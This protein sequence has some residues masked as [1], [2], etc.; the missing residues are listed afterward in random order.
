MK[1][2]IL[3]V[4]IAILVGCICF[5][6]LTA[7]N[8]T[9]NID[10]TS[11]SL[12]S[13]NVT[14]EVGETVNLAATIYPSNATDK[15]V[16]W[17]SSNT[18]IATVSNGLV[19]AKAEGI[20]IITVKTSNNK[21]ATCSI[22]VTPKTI[23]VTSVSL[24]L[25]N[26]TLE[27]GET[28][29]LTATI[30]PSNATDKS[31]T[32]RSSNTSVATVSNGLVTA[33]AEGITTITVK[34]SNNKTATCEVTVNEVFVFEEYGTGYALVA[35]KGSDS[36]VTVPSVYNGKDVI[37]IGAGKTTEY[38]YVQDAF[39]GNTNIKK[40]I[41]PDT[42]RNVNHASF[43]FCS[44]LEEIIMPKIKN[45]GAYAFYNCTSLKEIDLPTT[46][47][48]I[49]PYSF[50]GCKSLNNINFPSNLKTIQDYA[51]SECSALTNIKFQNNSVT[52]LY[53]AFDGCNLK[54]NI[55]VPSTPYKFHNWSTG[56]NSY[57]PN[58]VH[59]TVTINNVEVKIKN[60]TS[61]GASVMIYI[62]GKKTYDYYGTSHKVKFNYKIKN[63]N[64]VLASG[65]ITSVSV[66][67]GESFVAETA[68]SIS[69]KI[70][71]NELFD[72]NNLSLELI[73]VAW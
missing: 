2:K 12:N 27:V 7:C 54:I 65:T 55:N 46:L 10:V 24:N 1:K 70:P 57:I 4:L 34:T 73:E 21:T 14:L 30:Y 35:Y 32:W 71:I 41:L 64:T 23:A 36:I 42:V 69:I 68:Y 72:L 20:T 5:F 47:E 26:T 59:T 51:F 18:S 67:E 53:G 60:L 61:T 62:S 49:Y 17:R 19:K 22:T 6:T 43:M 38:Q 31:V 9:S 58:F 44:S 45:I 39:S 50:A 25:T 15:S 28:V 56:G 37:I 13:T 40:I 33:K 48:N 63:G 52:L 3:T 11:V 8:T 66:A 16:T 29:N